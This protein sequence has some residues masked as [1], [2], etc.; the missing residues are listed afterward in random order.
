MNSISGK[1]EATN[2]SSYGTR[3]A[4]DFTCEHLYIS[5][6]HKSHITARPHQDTELIKYSNLFK[7]NCQR[8]S[9]STQVRS[10]VCLQT[11]TSASFSSVKEI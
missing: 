2:R 1:L 3:L 5:Q 9:L 6:V 10:H 8:S 11:P 4:S 7:Y